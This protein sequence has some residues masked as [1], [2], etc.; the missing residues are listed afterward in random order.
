MKYPDRARRSTKAKHEKGRE[1]K[2][3]R[4]EKGD[5]Y[6]SGTQNSKKTKS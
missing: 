1:S 4:G 2:V 5:A 6:T 3:T